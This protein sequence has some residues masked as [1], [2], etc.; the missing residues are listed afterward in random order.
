MEKMI[1]FDL[2][3]TLWEASDSVSHSWNV[4]MEKMGLPERMTGEWMRRLMGQTMDAISSE[5]LPAKFQS[6][7][8]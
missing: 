6:V 3:G 1:L 4:A 8:G 2:D 7:K 5:L